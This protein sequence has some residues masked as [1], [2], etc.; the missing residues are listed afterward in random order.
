[1]IFLYHWCFSDNTNK[2]I[3]KPCRFPLVRK[4]KDIL[5]WPEISSQSQLC[6]LTRS[7]VFENFK[8]MQFRWGS[9]WLTGYDIRATRCAMTFWVILKSSANEKFLNLGKYFDPLP[10]MIHPGKRT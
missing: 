10:L 4:G 1:M 5:E 3:H 2:S 6:L 7:D 9:D 8:F